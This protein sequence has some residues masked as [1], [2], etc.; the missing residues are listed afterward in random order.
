MPSS[1]YNNV[2]SSEYQREKKWRASSAFLSNNS[3]TFCGGANPGFNPADPGLTLDFSPI[4]SRIKLDNSHCTGSH[5]PASYVKNTKI[6]TLYQA[7]ADLTIVSPDPTFQ[8]FRIQHQ[9]NFAATIYSNYLLAYRKKVN[10]YS[11]SLNIFT[12]Q[13]P[14]L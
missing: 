7:F 8:I 6:D 13:L 5:N 14:T 1:V 3:W 12:K 4:C 9:K 2:Q 10:M 11:M